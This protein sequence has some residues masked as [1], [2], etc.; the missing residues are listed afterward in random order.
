MHLY[1]QGYQDTHA[2]SVVG[3]FRSLLL[4]CCDLQSLARSLR[5][6]VSGYFSLEL[7]AS[8]FGRGKRI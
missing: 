8:E 7:R 6:R 4:C 3:L 2:P 1:I 5:V